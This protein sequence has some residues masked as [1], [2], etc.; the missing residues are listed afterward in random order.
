M[1]P[2]HS[3]PHPAATAI[4]DSSLLLT[5]PIQNPQRDLRNSFRRRFP[6][7]VSR[8]GRECYKT[9]FSSFPPTLPKEAERNSACF[10]CGG[11]WENQKTPSSCHLGRDG[12]GRPTSIPLAPGVHE[13]CTGAP[14]LTQDVY[15]CGTLGTNTGNCSRRGHLLA[16]VI[17]T[18]RKD[19][20]FY[21]L[22]TS[23][24][25]CSSLVSC[26][27]TLAF[28]PEPTKLCSSVQC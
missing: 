4:P 6:G 1:R 5:S 28:P 8:E 11:C 18:G 26:W 17:L 22:S 27:G 16:W 23:Q 9:P 21:Q 24:E 15:G 13:G 10:F 2:Q 25:I 12:E 20:S 3:C 7:E 19:P 14:L